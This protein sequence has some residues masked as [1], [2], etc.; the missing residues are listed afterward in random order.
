METQEELHKMR[1][2]QRE[3]T[4]WNRLN[5][6]KHEQQLASAETRVSELEQEVIANGLKSNGT[7]LKLPQNIDK[8][9]VIK[10]HSHLTKSL[11]IIGVLDNQITIVKKSCDEVVKSLKVEIADV[12]EER[13]KIELDLLNQLAKLDNEKQVT[14]D[15]LRIKLQSHKKEIEHLKSQLLSNPSNNNDMEAN[16]QGLDMKQEAG[17]GSTCSTTDPLSPSS[18]NSSSEIE[19]KLL[20]RIESLRLEKDDAIQEADMELQE[21][22]DRILKL[23]TCK[24]AHELTI[25][26]LKTENATIKEHNA[27]DTAEVIQKLTEDKEEARIAMQRVY[28]IQAATEESIKSLESELEILNNQDEIQ[29]KDMEGRE[30]IKSS[31]NN[32]LLVHEQIKTSLYVAELKLVNQMSALTDGKVLPEYAKRVLLKRRDSTIER[33]RQLQSNAILMIRDIEEEAKSKM[34]ILLEDR[35]AEIESLARDLSTSRCTI[36]ELEDVIESLNHDRQKKNKE[37]ND[38]DNNENDDSFVSAAVMNQLQDEVFSAVDRMKQKNKTITELTDALEESK[39]R[40][41]VLKKEVTRLTRKVQLLEGDDIL[42]SL[43]P[44]RWA[45]RH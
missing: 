3:E 1:I 24:N 12:M 42:S 28:E 6:Q 32:A 21:A 4:Y 25:S 13:S 26:K 7:H 14:E 37:S 40:E 41:G 2:Q 33:T 38:G 16:D 43:E 11:R 18:D 17:E 15:E 31:F 29:Q 35:Q 8:A 5:A 34:K 22:R 39:A 45:N 23:E 9:Y 10:I 44:S 20:R 36:A 19:S 30:S 27:F